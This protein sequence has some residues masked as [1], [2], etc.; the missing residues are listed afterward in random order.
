MSAALL[1]LQVNGLDPPKVARNDAARVDQHDVA[2][3]NV[4]G[5]NFHRLAAAPHDGRRRAHL[6]QRVD[7]LL[8]LAFLNHPDDRVNHDDGG[9]DDRVGHLAKEDRYDPRAEQDVDQR[10]VDLIDYHGKEAF[11]L[12]LGQSGFARS[13]QAANAPRR[14]T[15][16]TP[17]STP[18]AEAVSSIL[19][20]CHIGTPVKAQTKKRPS[21]SIVIWTT[22]VLHTK[23]V[24]LP[25]L[26]AEP[27]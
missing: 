17:G 20:L 12:F 8:G 23:K 4:P 10:V 6:L 16:R 11:P 1:D 27:Y 14:P 26:L 2:G 13:D 21:S 19:L 5:E 7:G 25:G 24:N 18:S 15:N 22:K 9:D 3:N